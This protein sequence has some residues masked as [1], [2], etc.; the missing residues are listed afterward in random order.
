MR[1]KIN[2]VL[3]FIDSLT[4]LLVLIVALFP[5]NFLRIILGLPFVLFFPGFILLSALFPR[6]GNFTDIERFALDF[7]LS[8]AIVPLLGLALNYTAWGITLN[9]VLYSLSAFVF[10]F[11]L[12]AWFRL[13]K[14][15]DAEKLALQVRITWWVKRSL[16][17]KILSIILVFVILSTIGV[18]IYTIAVPKT[19]ESYTEFYVLNSEG[20]ATNYP[21]HLNLGDTAEVTLDIVNR[22]L[23]NVTYRIE[24]KIDGDSAGS[25][26]PVTLK[27][28]EQYSTIASFKPQNAGTH[29]KV[30]F[31]LFKND[32]PTSYMDS[33]IW[34]DVQ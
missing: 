32:S 18:V 2:H 21:D 34:V 5:S 31:L 23:Q 19:N 30:E 24:I 9:S 29:Q 15:P 27:N 3:F 25:I 20:K 8:L 10:V 12:I 1:I 28:N 26:G 14:L 22:E 17:E 11:S 16:V 4:F 33:Y 7:G 6:K 13:R